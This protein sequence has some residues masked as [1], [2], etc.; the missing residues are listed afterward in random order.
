MKHVLIIFL[1]KTKNN[2]NKM[3]GSVTLFRPMSLKLCCLLLH[4]LCKLQTATS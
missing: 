4:L 3:L 1:P 2:W